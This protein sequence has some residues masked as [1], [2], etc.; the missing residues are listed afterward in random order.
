M[1]VTVL[2]D[3][4]LVLEAED[5]SGLE[6]L[7]GW[8]GDRRVRLGMRAWQR[9]AEVYATNALALPSALMTLAHR[10]ICDLLS[11]SPIESRLSDTEKA[12]SVGYRG[13]SATYDLLQGDIA[14]LGEI[15]D[16]LALGTHSQFWESDLT[17]LSCVPPPPADVRVHLEPNMPTPAEIRQ[18]SATFFA[19][20]RMV[21]IGG[22][23]DT[24]VIHAM[25]EHLGV[26]EELVRWIPSE[27]NKRA[28]NLKD[29]IRGLPGNSIVICI[30][31]KVGHDVSGEVKDNAS[32]KG[33]ILL[34][35]RFASQ[36]VDGLSE[37]VG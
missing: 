10:A 4:A 17:S 3:P 6:T 26:E 13:Q 34:E 14:G 18:R 7:L 1:T 32:R 15:D 11:R 21:I 19:G 2:L 28:R 35:P 25:N 20:R 9:V 27:K 8:V 5:E 24:Y 12:F 16:T 33:I 31:G 29:M 30:V 22:Q 37:L 23:K 36:I